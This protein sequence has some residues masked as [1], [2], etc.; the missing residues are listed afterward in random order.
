MINH[1]LI[2]VAALQVVFLPVIMS[3]LL[4]KTQSLLSYLWHGKSRY[5]VHS[6]FV[7]RYVNAVLRDKTQQPVWATIEAAREAL[8]HDTRTIAPQNLGAGQATQTRS[9]GQK[10]KQTAI[11]TLYGK[12]LYRTAAYFKAERVLELGAGTGISSF[13][14]AAAPSTRQMITIEGD[15][16]L[17]SIAQE[18]A[19]KLNLKNVE[20]IS[21]TFDATLPAALGKLGH[22]DLAFID[23]DH[24]KESTLAYYQ[25]ILPYTHNDTVLIFD[26][27]NWSPDMQE[28]WQSII[29]RP[30]VTL[31]LDMYRLGIVFFRKE[32]R[33]PQH[34]KLYYW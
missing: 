9:A 4:F 5:H 18:Q 31:S 12:L 8:K 15:A 32:I 33:Q 16:M 22:I 6:D 20:V 24:R 2:R 21:G 28:A 10:V 13:Y 34:L 19:H 1:F 23:G 14:L 29:A 25:T 17:A 7:Y 27:I 30:E 26:D 11:P 3:H